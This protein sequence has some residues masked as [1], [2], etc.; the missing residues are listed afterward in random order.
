MKRIL[1]VFCT[2]VMVGLLLGGCQ[3]DKENSS[4][5]IETPD[6]VETM[7]QQA[8]NSDTT[9]LVKG[10]ETVLLTVN[11]L[12]ETTKSSPSDVKQINEFGKALEE[13]WDKI[14][15]TVEKL[16][17]ESYIAI[18]KSLYPLIAEAKKPSPATDKIKTLAEDTTKKLE[19]YK[20]KIS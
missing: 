4:S 17:K 9:E 14:E 16:D 8:E 1:F 10:L 20:E 6:A 5:D 3:A 15:K 7:N 18:E 13:N 2:L 12:N 19:K 11:K